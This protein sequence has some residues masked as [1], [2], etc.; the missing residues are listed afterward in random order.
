[1][2]AA[3]EDWSERVALGF[4]VGVF[5][6]ANAIHDAHLLI[7]APDAARA[8][9]RYVAGNHDCSS[10]LTS[11]AGAGR[12]TTT[13]THADA[14]GPQRQAALVA[15]LERVAAAAPGL[16]LVTAVPAVPEASVDHGGPARAVGAPGGPLVAGVRDVARDGDWL[17]GYA[18]SL[19]AIAHVLDLAGAR[20][21][22]DAVAVVG[23]LMDRNEGDH[24]GN[25]RELERLLARLGLRVAS[26]WLSGG[27]VAELARVGEA[28]A[29]VSLPYG[30][31]AARLLG[32]R[33]G[34][35]VIEVD[36]PFGLDGTARWLR[37][38]G[39][40]TGR[41]ERAAAVAEEELARVVPLVDWTVPHH[42][43]HRSMAFVGDPHLALACEEAAVELGMTVARH[44]VL[45]GPPHVTRL[46][47]RCG[48]ERVVVDPKRT[49]LDR[50]VAA[51]VEGGRCQLLVA[52]SLGLPAGPMP[53]AM[54]E[55]GFPSYFTHALTDRPFLCFRGFVGFVERA[56]NELRRAELG[57]FDAS[58]R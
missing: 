33:L 11:G 30:R 58:R 23:Y 36:V 24:R 12:V 5:L 10:T 17:D 25:L 57:A 42:F 47:A 9:V 44:F 37:A 53:V 49:T 40:G 20:P 56:I 18:E 26:T 27:G 2:S 6:A 13:G 8:R 35:P 31:A 15:A 34:V 19:T 45:S 39:E 14:D 3:A 46:L 38:V 55:L 48:A 21:Q 4:P 22:P 32:V 43:L 52:C 1:M 41:G 28:S 50:D 51:L 54:V 29:I 7:D 16:V